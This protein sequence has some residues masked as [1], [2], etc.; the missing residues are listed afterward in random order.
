MPLLASVFEA[1]SSQFSDYVVYV[2]DDFDIIVVARPTGTIPEPDQAAVSAP[3][4]SSELKRVGINGL[5]DVLVRRIGNKRALQPLFESYK[6][7]A[8]S[9]Y[10]PLLDLYAARALFMGTSVSDLTKN[11][12]LQL[13]PAVEMLGHEP[14]NLN[15]E[16]VSVASFKRSAKI[17]IANMLSGYILFGRPWKM[18]PS[19]GRSA[20]ELRKYTDKVRLALSGCSGKIS[21]DEWWDG[22][23]YIMA[24]CILPYSSPNQLAHFWQK[25][26]SS[27]CWSRMT[28]SQKDFI[29]L[30]KAVD[31]RDAMMMSQTARK[32]LEEMPTVHTILQEY[33]LAAGLLGDL[34]L[35]KTQDARSLWEKY[36]QSL[37]NKESHSLLLRFLIAHIEY[38]TQ[39]AVSSSVQR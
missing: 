25:A 12:D 22:T 1:L 20:N 18:D 15:S 13:L 29:K 35:G 27:S 16:E 30:L 11:P 21:P 2:T 37:G 8:N 26:E 38:P 5:Q 24:Q 10:Y 3:G 23:F 14:V 31:A 17:R 28:P 34:S 33:I 32:L 19:E 36:G 4:L 6:V 39:G 9:D 7:P